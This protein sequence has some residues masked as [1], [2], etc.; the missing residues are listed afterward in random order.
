VAGHLRT[1]V[2]AYLVLVSGMVFSGVLSGSLRSQ[3]EVREEQ[4]F[5]QKSKELLGAAKMINE[6]IKEG[7]PTLYGSKP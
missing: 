6:W 2:L 5:R 4:F 3:Y 1:F 7:E